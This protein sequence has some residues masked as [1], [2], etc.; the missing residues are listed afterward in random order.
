MKIHRFIW[1]SAFLFTLIPA[2]VAGQAAGGHPG[3]DVQRPSVFVIGGVHRLSGAGAAGFRATPLRGLGLRGR[4]GPGTVFTQVEVGAMAPTEDGRERYE[5]MS[6]FGGYLLD[7]GL[8]ARMVF[9]VGPTVGL[10]R[11]RGPNLAGP[12]EDE[13]VL[14]GRAEVGFPRWRGWEAG[15]VGDVQRVQHRRPVDFL[16]VG[17]RVGREIGLPRGVARAVLGSGAA[18]REAT[19]P[20]DGDP[21][22]APALAPAR[23]LTRIDLERSGIDRLQQLP[24]LLG[25]W[26][27]STPNGIA[28][29]LSAP[30]GTPYE[31]TGWRVFVD[32]VE[33]PL[34]LL[35]TASLSRLP[36]SLL[37]VDSIQVHDGAGIVA[38]HLVTGGALHFFTGT[39]PGFR[40][41]GQI[42]GANGAGEPGLQLD[43]PNLDRLGGGKSG[44]VGYGADR[45]GV[46]VS[47]SSAGDFLTDPPIRARTRAATVERLP[48][49]THSDL[50][51]RMVGVDLRAMGG[52]HRLRVALSRGRDF[53]FL[54]PLGGERVAENLATRA[55]LS[56]GWAAGPHRVGFTYQGGFTRRSLDPVAGQRGTGL[57][58]EQDVLDV[59]ATASTPHW[60]ITVAGRR[61]SGRSTRFALEDA[62]FRRWEAR[63]TRTGGDWLVAAGGGQGGGQATADVLGSWSPE[64]SS[65]LRLQAS[66]LAAWSAPDDPSTLWYWDRRGYGLVGEAGVSVLGTSR[67]GAS[68]MVMSETS[69]RR[70][71]PKTVIRSASEAGQMKRESTFSIDVCLAGSKVRIVEISS[72]KNST[73]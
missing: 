57:A 53:F 66:L 6:G 36:V 19:P 45:G 37:A 3:D 12:T 52:T 67:P 11:I 21:G 46:T 31:Q 41:G 5:V 42:A 13:I 43:P 60:G 35:G 24:T 55:T 7:V 50:A 69:L 29:W 63:L 59:G 61:V 65:G 20:S 25:G 10:F 8:P 14:G 64:L 1:T 23:T 39:P 56:G 28:T 34:A 40:L 9:S 72:P 27:A 73:R 48:G 58:F 70:R 33:L 47:A 30:G 71:A 4:A 49:G 16:R 26:S 51:H 44:L 2:C 17:V 38:G 15:V 62:A 18:R 54:A 68:L 32:G 22:R